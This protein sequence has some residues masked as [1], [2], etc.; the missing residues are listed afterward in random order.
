MVFLDVADR[1]PLMMMPWTAGLDGV[2][3]ARAIE[4]ARN[5]AAPALN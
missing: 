3:L 1:E 2:A 5:G 4:R